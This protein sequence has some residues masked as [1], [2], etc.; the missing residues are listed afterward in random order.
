MC[1]GIPMQVVETEGVFAW[2][3]GRN[4]RQRI[5]TMLVGDVV[6]GQWL[7]T[8]LDTAREAIDAERALLVNSALDALDLAAT[9]NNDFDSCFAD[10][11]NREPQLPDFL[12]QKS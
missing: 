8:F 11:I 7:L 1:L 12:R 3:Y 9:G 5:N 6:P 2:C 4:G 10:L